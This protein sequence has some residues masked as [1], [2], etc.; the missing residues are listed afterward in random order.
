MSNRNHSLDILR[1]L[2]SVLVVNCHLA[3]TLGGDGTLS[4]LQLGGRGV[5]LFFVLSG[6]LLGHQLLAELRKTGKVEVG[7]FWRRRWLRT[8]PATCRSWRFPWRSQRRAP[9]S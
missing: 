1:S 8:L 6:W 4:A 3:S 5:D 9:H 7:R 2:A